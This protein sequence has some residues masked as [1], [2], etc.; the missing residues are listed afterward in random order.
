MSEI[1]N[2]NPESTE[3]PVVENLNPI[4]LAEEIQAEVES[5][6]AIEANLMEGVDE[7]DDLNK[8]N[9]I[10]I[11]PTLYIKPVESDKTDDKG[12]KIELYQ[13]LNPVT[14]TVE[15]RELTGEE[16]HEIQVLRIKESH[17]KFRPI[18]HGVKTVGTQTIVSSIGRERKVKSKEIQTNITVNQFGA[19]YRKKRQR[20]NKMQKASRKANR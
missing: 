10:K 13:I 5:E 8:K 14:E 18:K 7:T 4:S 1:D 11:T 3:L 17:I 2:V 15:T 6:V 20:K 9:Y 16:K 19:D 12:E